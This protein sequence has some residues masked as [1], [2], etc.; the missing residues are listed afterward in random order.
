MLVS[1]RTPFLPGT[2]TLSRTTADEPVRA[3]NALRRT[4]DA[5]FACLATL[6]QEPSLRPL[7][8]NPEFESM[9]AETG[10]RHR[11]AV[12]AFE[13]AGGDTLLI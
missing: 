5:G 2:C 12:E 11:R 6:D 10:R 4:V 8:G 9:R 3:L 7:H 13:N 1:T